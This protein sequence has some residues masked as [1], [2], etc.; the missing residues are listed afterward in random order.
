MLFLMAT[1][2][3]VTIGIFD[4]S[5][6]MA[7][8]VELLGAAGFEDTAVYDGATIGHEQQNAPP[9]GPVPVGSILVPS[10]LCAEDSSSG[11]P[12][13]RTF[14]SYLADYHLPDEAV[15]GYATTFC[16][17]GKFLLVRTHPQR[18]EEVVR[19]LRKCG[20]SRV[21]RYD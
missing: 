8:A 13:V 4:D 19:I 14:K 2:R 5:R 15:E 18:D 7:R 11:E 3:S 9:I 21:N 16:H 20:A 1:V 6:D 12:A 17:D 10:S